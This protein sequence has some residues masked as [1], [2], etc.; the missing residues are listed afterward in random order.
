MGED[1]PE[2]MEGTSA[3]GGANTQPSQPRPRRALTTLNDLIWSAALNPG[4]RRH[5]EA[6]SGNS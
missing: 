6:D 1:R 5:S 2:R 3:L 4:A